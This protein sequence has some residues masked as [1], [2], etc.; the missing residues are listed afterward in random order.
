MLAVISTQYIFKTCITL[1][2]NQIV[3]KINSV[4]YKLHVKLL[5]EP[6]SPKLLPTNREFHQM[7]GGP[8]G[9]T[10]LEY[11]ILS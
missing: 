3:P 4:S 9:Q 7:F 10:D 6:T 2:T 5:P 1:F 8:I 11:F